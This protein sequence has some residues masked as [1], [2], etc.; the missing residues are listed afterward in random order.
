MSS[1]YRLNGYLLPVL[2][3]ALLCMQLIDPSRV[4][5]VL[6]VGLGGLWLV[7]FLWARALSRHI[8][9]VRE[10]RYGWVQVGDAL[11]ERFTV[12]NGG[13]FPATWLEIED[14]STLP[15][16][17]ASLATGVGGMDDN[18]WL[19]KGTCSRRGLYW[20]GDTLVHTGDPFGIYTVTI[21][22]PARASL[23]VMPPIVPLPPLDI[24]PGGYGGEGRPLPHAP[25]DTIDASS[26][27]EYVQG[28]SA[29]LIHWKT[30]AR[31]EKPFVRL[32]DGAPASDWW[33]LLD[34]HEKVQVGQGQDST[35]ELGVILA[36]SLANHG[37]RE[38]LG[39]GL[40][41]NGGQLGWLPPR[42]GAGQGWEMLRVLALASRG[43][44][45]LIE[46]LEHTRPVLGKNSSMLVITPSVETNWLE[47]LPRLRWRGITPTVLSLNPRSFGAGRDNR[48]LL[49]ALEKMG[50]P[51][52]DIPREIL[53]RP[54]AAPGTRGQWEWRIS[55]TG[56][57]IPV[58]S[59]E[60]S[61]WRRLSE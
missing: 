21:R 23:M 31:L 57:A 58:R 47:S 28:D 2:V 59:P 27:R 56:R 43:D 54:E 9:L 39:V 50:V 22:D 25:E 26:V 52:Y 5:T 36:A 46:V 42:S 15:G 16:Y 19:R 48:G 8:R 18:H 17:D 12:K 33:I 1:R 6:L 24:L 14:R 3:V 40:V 49:A 61:D 10:M 7:T 51:H 53:D 55:P 35:E 34:L 29:R 38:N 45:P 32:F 37:L 4:W 13:I 60:D 44:T 41:V 20:L 30:T 11:E